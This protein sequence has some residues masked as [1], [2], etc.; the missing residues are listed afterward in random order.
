MKPIEELGRAAV[1]ARLKRLHDLD[2]LSEEQKAERTQLEARE[3]VLYREEHPPI[4][5]PPNFIERDLDW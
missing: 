3:W 1:R 2:S 5:T 4:K